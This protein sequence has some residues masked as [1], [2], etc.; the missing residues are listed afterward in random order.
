MRPPHATYD[1]PQI[2]AELVR[3]LRGDRSQTALSRRLG[4]KTNVVY[5][6]EA[7]K[8]A[9]TGAGFFA[10][11]AKVGISPEEA[12]ATFYRTR[13][14][15]LAHSPPET[16]DGTAALLDDLRGSRTLVETARAL[17]CSRYALARWLRGEAEPRLPDFLEVIEVTSLRLLD[18]VAAFV[19]PEKLPSLR[20]PWLRLQDARRA[21]Y[22]M[23]W[24]HAILRALE[25][26]PYAA[27]EKHPEGWIAERLGL[28]THVEQEALHL[29][30]RTGQIHFARGK[31]HVTTTQTIDTRRDPE[32]AKRLKAWW[33]GIGRE[34]FLQGAPG[35]FSYNVFGVSKK[36]LKRLEELQRA[37]FRELRSI[38]AESEPVETVAVVNL[39]MFSLLDGGAPPLS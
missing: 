3:A 10:L 7:Q 2:A 21:A 26:V 1:Y 29:L 33:F 16:R 32:A 20:E 30:E 4:Y 12:I 9:P 25:L 14:G 6:W 31:W 24:S 15:W 22:E 17:R 36:D 11:A 18:F 39:Q 37:Y 28:P 27:F 8:G 13:P 5:V 35:V 23:P 19:D 34:R 38:V